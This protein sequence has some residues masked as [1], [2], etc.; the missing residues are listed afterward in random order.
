MDK[1]K[2]TEPVRKALIHLT[3]ALFTGTLLVIVLLGPVVH[4]SAEYF[5]NASGGEM[6]PPRITRALLDA[7]EE[8]RYNWY[9][10]IMIM[11]PFPV[12]IAY[13]AIRG[14]IDNHFAVTLTKYFRPRI[15]HLAA[16]IVWLAFLLI[17]AYIV[18][19]GLPLFLPPHVN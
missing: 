10:Y 15:T 14:S 6:P 7:S 11:L 19:A 1:S 3:V 8:F 2:S 17:N 5:L 13:A 4:I 9:W 12:G 18:S 16:V